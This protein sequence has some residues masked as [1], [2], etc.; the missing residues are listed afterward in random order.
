MT[1]AALLE[2]LNQNIAGGTLTL[3]KGAISSPQIDALYED[4]LLNAALVINNVVV[5]AETDKITVTGQGN[6][7]IFFST[8]AA[9]LTFT[10]DAAQLPVMSIQADA[11]MALKDGWTFGKSFPSLE[12]SLWGGYYSPSDPTIWIQTVFFET[13]RF[14]LSGHELLFNGNLVLTEWLRAIGVLFNISN[15]PLSG[16]VTINKGSGTYVGTAETA[17]PVTVLDPLDASIVISLGSFPPLTLSLQMVSRLYTLDFGPEIGRPAAQLE[18]LIKSTF[19]FKDSELGLAIVVGGQADAL[20]MRAILPEDEE[21]GITELISLANN[22]NILALMPSS[23]PVI[24]DF[25]LK[26]FEI[27]FSTKQAVPSLSMVTLGVATR[28]SFSWTLI[29]NL[30]TLTSIELDMVMGYMNG[31]FNPSMAIESVITIGEEPNF[32]NIILSGSFPSYVFVGSLDPETPIDLRGLIIYFMGESV[33]DS[34]PDTLQLGTLTLTVD[35]KNSTYSLETAL[36]TDFQID[37]GMAVIVVRT[38]AFNI[39]YIAGAAT[40]NVN[41]EFQV[42]TGVDAPFMFVSAAYNGPQEGWVFSGG[43]QDGSKIN[44]SELISSYLPAAY[45]S[46]I[47]TGI[48]INTLFASFTYGPVKTYDFRL[49]AEWTLDL[50]GYFITATGLVQISYTKPAPGQLPVYNGFVEGALDFGNIRVGARIA[51][52][53]VKP[54]DYTFFFNGFTASLKTILG[55]RV[56]VFAFT[57]NTTLGSLIELLVNAATGQDIT[58]PSPWNVMNNIQMRNF[59]FSFNLTKNK[60]GLTHKANINLGF[61]NIKGISLYYTYYPDSTTPPLVEIGFSADS[62]FLG[63]AT[64]LPLPWNVL[65]PSAAPPVPGQGTNLFR[66]EFLGMGQHVSLKDNLSP[67]TVSEAVLLLKDA[68]E[69]KNANPKIPPKTPIEGTGLKF[70]SSSNWLI[71]TEFLIVDTFA[72]G[73]V[74]FDPDLY[75]LS[76]YVNGPKAKIFQGLKFEILYKKVSDTVGVYQVFLKLPDAIRQLNFGAV[77]VTLPSVKIYIYTNGD[78]KIDFGFPVKDDFSESFGI[79]VLPFIGS[80]GL[81]F[82]MLSAETAPTVPKSSTGNFSPVIV[83]GVGLKIGVGKE[84]NQGILKAGISIAVQGILEGTFAQFNWYDGR[85]DDLAYYYVLGKIALV[86]HIYGG[87][88]FLI[89]TAEVDIRVYVSLRL[90]FESYEPMLITLAA[91]VSVALRVSVNLGI[92]RINVNLSFTTTIQESFTIGTSLPK[93]WGGNELYA[94]HFRQLQ[95]RALDSEN[96]CPVVPDMNWQPVVPVEK[97]ALDILFIPQFSALTDENSSVQKACATAMLYLESSIDS[98]SSKQSLLKNGVLEETDFPFTKFAKGVLLWVFGAY[99]NKGEEGIPASTVLGEEVTIE[100]LNQI[101]C[102]FSE[103]EAAGPFSVAQIMAFMENYL[104]ATLVTP[105]VATEDIE[106]KSVS[107]LP[108]LPGLVLETPSGEVFFSDEKAQ[109]TYTQQQLGLI[110]DYFK[111]LSVRNKGEDKAP[112]ATPSLEETGQS[113][114]SFMLIDYISL[115]A[116]ESI[117]K[118]IDIMKNLAV[119]VK[120]GESVDDLVRKYPNLGISAVELAFSNRTRALSKGAALH[121]KTVRYT[122]RENETPDTIIAKFNLPGHDLQGIAGPFEAGMTLTLPDFKHTVEEGQ[123]LLHIARKYGVDVLGIIAENTH[124]PGLFP[125]G[126]RIVVP[127][128]ESMTVAD[129]IAAM[130]AHYDFEQL[131]GLSANIM[132]QGLRVPLPGSNNEVGKPEALY[133]VSGQEVDASAFVAGNALTLKPDA[134]TSWLNFGTVDGTTL[135]YVFTAEDI[136]ALQSLQNSKLKPYL[137]ELKASDLYAIQPRK[138]TLPSYVMWQI[139]QALTLVNGDNRLQETVDP[140]IWAFKDSLQAMLNGYDVVTPKVRLL[141]QVQ[142]TKISADA[143]EPVNNYSWSTTINVKLAQVKS[144]ENP[145]LL[146]PNVYEVQGIDQNAMLLLQNLLAWYGKNPESQ[147]L[148]EIQI[149]YTKEPAKEGQEVPPNG[150]RSDSLSNTSVFLL[151]TNLST[152]SNPPQLDTRMNV[153]ATPG[154]QENLIGMSQLEFLTY[155]WEAAVV[156]TGGYYLYYQLKDSKAGLP[157]YLFNGDTN[158]TVTLVVTYHITD[159]VLQNFL[160]SVVITDPV[161][162]QDEILYIETEAMQLA[163]IETGDETLEVFAKRYSTKISAIADRNKHVP[164]KKGNSLKIPLMLKGETSYILSQENDSLATLAQQH[165]TSVMALAYANKNVKQLFAGPI[166]FDTRTEIKVATVPPGNIGFTMTRENPDDVPDAGTADKNLQQLYNLLGYNIGKNDD[167]DASVPGLPV[168]PGDNQYVPPADIDNVVRPSALSGDDL[169]YNRILPVYPFVKTIEVAIQEENI[170]AEKDNPYRAVGKTVLIDMRWHDIFGNLTSFE[171]A[172]APNVPASLPPVYIGYTDPVMGVSLYPSFSASYIIEKPVEGVPTLYITLAFNPTN[173]VPADEADE[174]WKVRTAVDI[175]SYRQI[176]YQLLQEDVKVTVSNSLQSGSSMEEGKETLR[177]MVL[178]IYQYLGGL[179]AAVVPFAFYTVQEN[180]TLDSVAAAYQTTPENIRR[181]N[182]IP[183]DGILTVGS[184]LIITAIVIPGNTIIETPVLDTNSLNLFALVTTISITRDIDLVDDNFKDE[185]SVIGATSVLSPN[186]SRNGTN[187]TDVQGDGISI[188]EFATKLQNAF[189]ELK[190]A[191]GTPQPGSEDNSSE[192]IWVVRFDESSTGVKFDIQNTGNPFYFALLPLSTHLLSRDKVKIYPYVTGT[193]IAS[194]SPVESSFNGVDIEKL[195]ETCLSAIDVFLQADFSVPAW[196]VENSVGIQTENAGEIIKPYEQVIQAKKTLADNIVGHLSTVLEDGNT[197][198]DGNL[199]NA[200]ERLKQELLISLSNAYSIDTVVQFNVNV[201]S[202][203]TGIGAN[204]PQLFGKVADPLADTQ[205]DQQAYAFSTTRFSLANS[206]TGAGDH[207]YLTILFN[208]KKESD[209]DNANS[210]FPIDL[211]Y[212]INSIEHAITDVEGIAGYKASSW[213]TFIVPFGDTGTDLGHLKIPI[214]LRAYPTAPSLTAQD[215]TYNGKSASLKSLKAEDALEEAKLW[216]YS[217]TYDYLRAQQDTINTDII[218]N[219]TAESV[220]SRLFDDEEEPD[221]F[222]A[223]LQ[224][225]SAYPGIQ[226][227]FSQYV[228]GQLADTDFY[229]AMQSFAWLVQRVAAAWGNW[230][231]DQAMYRDFNSNEANY[232]YEIIES[233]KEVETGSGT[234][235]ALLIMVIPKPGTTYRLPDVNIN[236]FDHEVVENTDKLKSFV[237]YRTNGEGVKTY[238]SPSDARKI[239]QR[240]ISYSNFNII[241]EE[242]VWSG[243][244]VIRNKI[245]VPDMVTNSQFIYTTPTVR[246][247]SVMTPLLDPDILIDMSDYTPHTEKQYLKAYL[248]N[249]IK[250]LF[251]EIANDVTVRQIKIATAYSYNLQED[252]EGLNTVIPISITTPYDFQ[253]PAD[254]DISGCPPLAH[255]I[256]ADSP[257]VCQLTALIENW[258]MTNRPSLNNAQFRFDISLFSGLSNTQLPVLRLRNI[259]LQEDVIKWE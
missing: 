182:T 113:L 224:F 171:N 43:L 242:N 73:I 27:S 115:L 17:V 33:A 49:G 85:N 216:G 90:V 111:T 193:P 44:L 195:A 63:G 139:P 243:L 153:G 199:A 45:Q 22:E 106:E 173:Y 31:Q 219:V 150:L 65:E 230:T 108:I 233:E 40:G 1:L 162:I 101:L 211:Q 23:M 42:G 149:L 202:P 228:S 104:D 19:P 206:D 248:S 13:A 236:G 50:D 135:P 16:A 200:Q 168:A 155:M 169:Q 247:V 120:A 80:G 28:E 250:Q 117:Q 81:Y 68:F 164:L 89:I 225:S 191:S 72:I 136:T 160:N 122:V 26:Q 239:T 254:W 124:I 147:L 58:L 10:L 114:A 32:V 238:L 256:Q 11:L 166:T 55:D 38:V 222:A 60:I 79:Q 187:S 102:Y 165:G 180:D 74:F 86:G 30:I 220:Q 210:Y 176:Y 92:F 35:P 116:K 213:L 141:K 189:P 209:T 130:D 244:S 5:T 25:Y 2:I 237:Y 126:K 36:T 229:T 54:N 14:R 234:E 131:S 175:E 121:L 123:S 205:T 207:S 156:G 87:V 69:R 226:N 57:D 232:N 133:K 48:K 184:I 158:G 196:L 148:N 159:N 77:A 109:Y 249:F 170:P 227:D 186:L 51:F 252:V 138:F 97:V 47:P 151:Q 70:N 71:G 188:Q 67:N 34:L 134:S 103:N 20:T 94:A 204:P 179:L 12:Y 96:A 163:D 251:R 61:I 127:F 21:I 125:A 137:I 18:V 145:A 235:L 215:F 255:D 129:L 75:G 221:L 41:G 192:A 245:L 143:P 118:G 181:I 152:L 4:F 64:Q 7:F 110:R 194:Q 37:A 119:T 46:V 172:T 157:D 146:M 144:A 161:D 84:I 24:Y 128:A 190:A 107:V 223:L 83:F 82:G 29:P 201:T 203:Y 88:N 174:T 105:P 66:L 177:D 62:T 257:F 208:S 167:F 214:P 100:V 183:A 259:Y 9:P 142:V 56:I 217:Y 185:P 178:E 99:Y 98:T 231:E 8:E 52:D 95:F 91:G 78:F 253:I 218:L 53:A 198:G 212:E 59:E 258:F 154:M 240:N 6:S 112:K 140:S 76:V 246:F 93:P 15:M 132:L 3:P 39:N 241:Q 197:P